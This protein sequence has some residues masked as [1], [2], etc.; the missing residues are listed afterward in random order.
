MRSSPRFPPAPPRVSRARREARAMA[1]I[2]DQV[3]SMRALTPLQWAALAAAIAMALGWGAFVAVA[4]PSAALI[5]AAAIV[6]VFT[7][8]D[9]RVGV[10]MMILIMPISASYIF[11]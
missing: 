6:C 11:P 2:L 9:F 8:R 4:G 10:M 3:S 7:V 5:C 1:A